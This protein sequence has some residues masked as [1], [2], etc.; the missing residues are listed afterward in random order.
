MAE[1]MGALMRSML[2]NIDCEDVDK[3][4]KQILA[5][6]YNLAFPYDPIH[7]Y[8]EKIRNKIWKEVQIIQPENPL[9]KFI[10]NSPPPIPTVT[11]Y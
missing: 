9:I 6:M 2:N 7:D 11:T 10:K 4:N 3:S 8:C 1:T 5:E